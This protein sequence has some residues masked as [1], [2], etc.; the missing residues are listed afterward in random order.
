VS[1]NA[2]INTLL[3][4]VESLYLPCRYFGLSGSDCLSCIIT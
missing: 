2:H 1:V 3:A 4:K